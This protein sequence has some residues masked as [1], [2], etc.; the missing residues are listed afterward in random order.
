[1]SFLSLLNK[2]GIVKR[3]VAGSINDYGESVASFLIIASGIKCRVE[4]NRVSDKDDEPGNTERGNFTIFTTELAPVIARDEIWVDSKRY[5]VVKTMD[6]A[7]H[8]HHLEIEANE[9]EQV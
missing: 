8:G 6:A 4:P 3:G 7:G 5:R 2:T 9:I 1:M